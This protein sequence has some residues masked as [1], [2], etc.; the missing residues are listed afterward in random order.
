MNEIAIIVTALR[1]R[2]ARLNDEIKRHGRSH[3]KHANNI[4]AY[5]DARRV[6][7]EIEDKRLGDWVLYRPWAG[8]SRH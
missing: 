6:L 3:P 2:I 5:T 7:D 4:A 8:P 1:E